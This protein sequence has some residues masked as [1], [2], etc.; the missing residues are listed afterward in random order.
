ME[1]WVEV[2]TE[3]KVGT[4]EAEKDEEMASRGDE[5]VMDLGEA[6]VGMA[7]EVD[8]LESEEAKDAEEVVEMEVVED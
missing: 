1:D 8:I 2:L 4:V 5:G 3:V 6:E 7:A